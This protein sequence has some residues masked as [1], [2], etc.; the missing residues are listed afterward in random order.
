MTPCPVST[1]HTWHIHGNHRCD[2]SQSIKA[3]LFQL[4]C[5][6][7]IYLGAIFYTHRKFS[8]DKHII[9][10]SLSLKMFIFQSAP[11]ILDSKY[12]LDTST[13]GS[14]LHRL[15]TPCSHSMDFTVFFT[16][17]REQIMMDFYVLPEV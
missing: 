3:R 8:I 9:Y 4:I 12:F 6:L 11:R 1:G 2:G 15:P 13:A 17:N 5:L 10:L 7:R 16:L 14:L